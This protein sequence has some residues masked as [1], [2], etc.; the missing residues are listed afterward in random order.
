MLKISVMWNQLLI[1]L[2]KNWIQ[3]HLESTSVCPLTTEYVKFYRR[4]GLE[5]WRHYFLMV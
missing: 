3:W 5:T 1:S 4:R 2:H